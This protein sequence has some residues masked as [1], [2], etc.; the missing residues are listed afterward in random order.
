MR[1]NNLFF[2]PKQKLELAQ[3]SIEPKVA[4]CTSFTFKLDIFDME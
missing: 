4:S 3:F 2:R 1:S